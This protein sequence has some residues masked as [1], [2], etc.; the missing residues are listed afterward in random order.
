[1]CIYIYKYMYGHPPRSILK[2]L[3]LPSLTYKY[4]I[5]SSRTAENTVNNGVFATF[6]KYFICCNYYCVVL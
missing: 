1:M 2:G 6:S 5:D 4:I 3:A